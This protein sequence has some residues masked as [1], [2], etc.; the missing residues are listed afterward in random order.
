VVAPQ[1]WFV[2]DDAAEATLREEFARLA[3]RELGKDEVKLARTCVQGGDVWAQG[4]DPEAIPTLSL[5]LTSLTNRPLIILSSEAELLRARQIRF[6][7]RANC[8]LM[9]HEGST[10][11]RRAATDALAAFAGGT[12]TE[13]GVVWCT[14]EALRDAEVQ[15]AITASC[16]LALLVE[17]AH[18]VSPRAHELRPSLALVPRVRGACEGASLVGFTRAASADVREDAAARLGLGPSSLAVVHAPLASSRVRLSVNGLSGNGSESTA[19]DQSTARDKQKTELAALVQRLPRP[20]A[21]FCAT[22][23]EA[24]EV[25]SLLTAE[26]VPVHRYHGAMPTSDRATEMLHFTL[27]GRRAVMVAV[28][29]F[30]PGSGL[31]GVDAGPA[32]TP[33]GLGLGFGRQKLRSL[34]H[35]CAPASLEQYAQEL[36]LLCDG[37]ESAEAVLFLSPQSLHQTAATVGKVRVTSLEIEAV[38]RALGAAFSSSSTDSSSKRGSSTR[39]PLSLQALERQ[40]G[41]GR[42]A[43]LRVVRIFADAGLVRLEAAA[44][45]VAATDSAGAS[46]EVL[47]HLNVTP[48][49]LMQ[50]ASLLDSDLAELRARDTERLDALVAYAGAQCCRHV[51]LQRRFA[52]AASGES[53]SEAVDVPKGC[54]TC[55][56]CRP[57]RVASRK[58]TDSTALV[59]RR[60]GMAQ[61]WGSE[62]AEPRANEDDDDSSFERQPPRRSAAL[63]IARD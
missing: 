2:W 52:E 62:S 35:F 46:A 50:A 1:P 42:K 22:P 17:G 58:S 44:P 45:T 29:A 63:G 48:A 8:W 14:L 34:V 16:P 18:A 55:D 59:V 57:E 28:S 7:A 27:P 12:R 23:H 51:T 38:A 3:Q 40:A 37:E 32:A 9:D 24:D 19:R 36:A 15:Q 31:A 53:A 54:G 21:V 49:D 5:A 10:A 13:G 61:A 56:R 25:F 47:V 20:T 30:Q 60:R 39:G 4:F 43:T 26:Q 41:V 33:E 11:S 6:G